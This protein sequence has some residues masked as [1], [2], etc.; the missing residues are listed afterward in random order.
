MRQAFPGDFKSLGIQR[1]MIM[2]SRLTRGSD[3]ASVRL[4]LKCVTAVTARAILTALVATMRVFMF[5]VFC[6]L[7]A[8]G[9]TILASSVTLRRDSFRCPGT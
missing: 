1:L 9:S 7:T 5:T 4:V 8:T 6:L 2:R 3:S